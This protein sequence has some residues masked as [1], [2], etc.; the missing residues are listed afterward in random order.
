M[1][2][3]MIALLLTLALAGHA[4]AQA[5]GDA[6]MSALRT[7]LAPGK[8]VFVARQL[9]LSPAEE[10]AFWPIYDTQQTG[11][12]ELA[13]R[14][15]ANIAAL[16]AATANTDEDEAEDLAKEALA[17]EADEARLLDRT[18]GRMVRAVGQAK[19]LQYLRIELKLAALARYDAA[20][21]LP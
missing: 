15:R 11:L 13:A 3:L 6:S 18:Y 5:G 19:S 20:S 21:A 12:A 2:R 9:A 1:F 7:A 10:A 4:Q 8:Q 17:I 16:A 14:R